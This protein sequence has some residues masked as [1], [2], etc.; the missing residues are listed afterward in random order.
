VAEAL[1]KRGV[2]S[3]WVLEGGLEAWELD[4]RPVTTKL[5]T[6]EEIAE[7]LGIV[8]PPEVRLRKR[9]AAS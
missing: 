5:K 1:E 9:E 6:P 7:R 3:V 2:S 8:L 4:G